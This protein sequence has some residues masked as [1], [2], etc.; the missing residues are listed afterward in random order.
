MRW[1]LIWAMKPSPLWLKTT[2]RVT[3]ITMLW[4]CN[5]RPTGAKLKAITRIQ[6]NATRVMT[7][8]GYCMV[9]GH[10]ITVGF[11]PIAIHPNGPRP[12]ARQT[13]WLISW[14]QVDWHG[15]SGKSMGFVRD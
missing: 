14:V 9:L 5:G 8:A 4:R 6:T 15:I 12:V 11:H 1:L 10:N 13:R 2:K 3:L 7:M